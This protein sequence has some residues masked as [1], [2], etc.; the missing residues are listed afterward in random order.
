MATKVMKDNFRRLKVL[1]LKILFIC[2]KDNHAKS[3]TYR[4][5]IKKDFQF[6][7]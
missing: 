7:P 5:A 4:T 3:V 1:S 2:S 6:I